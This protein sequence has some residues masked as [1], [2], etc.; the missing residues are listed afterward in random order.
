MSGVLAGVIKGEVTA[1]P[2]AEVVAEEETSRPA[3]A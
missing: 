1:T 2:L 3:H